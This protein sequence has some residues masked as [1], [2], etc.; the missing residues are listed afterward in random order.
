MERGED[1]PS[2]LAEA[3]RFDS[4]IVVEEGV[5]EAREIEV[6]VLEGARTLYELQE[7]TKVST[8]CGQCKDE[9]T[10]L[11]HTYVDKHFS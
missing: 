6:A 1:L 3:R 8:G 10:T 4:K 5:S 11:L 9:V 7:M 2:A